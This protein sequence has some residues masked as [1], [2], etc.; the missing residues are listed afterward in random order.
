MREK[1]LF[2]EKEIANQWDVKVMSDDIERSLRVCWRQRKESRTETFKRW[3]FGLWKKV[4]EV[5]KCGEDFEEIKTLKKYNYY[6]TR[7]LDQKDSNLL[8]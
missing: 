2:M 3:N 7:P 8:F 1:K 4:M 6:R 5:V